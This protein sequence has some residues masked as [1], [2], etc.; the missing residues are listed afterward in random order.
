MAT[1]VVGFRYQMARI[2]RGRAERRKLPATVPRTLE[3][4][5]GFFELRLPRVSD[6]RYF[7]NTSAASARYAHGRFGVDRIA[8]RTTRSSPFAGKTDGR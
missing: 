3:N 6:N 7:G 1:R 2:R 5:F 4:G 8:L